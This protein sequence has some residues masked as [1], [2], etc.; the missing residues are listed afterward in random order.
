MREPR[1]TSR[2]V[3]AAALLHVVVAS[4]LPAASESP[5]V[6][7]ASERLAERVSH[8]ETLCGSRPRKMSVGSTCTRA[9]TVRDSI[10]L[11]RIIPFKDEWD[12]NPASGTV[13]FSRDRGSFVFKTVRGDLDRNV[14]VEELLVVRTADLSASLSP[15][16]VAIGAQGVPYR[17][18]VSVVVS[19]AWG[20]I[21]D[22]RWINDEE[23]GYIAQGDTNVTQAF[24]VNSKTGKTRQLTHS[25]GDV[26]GFDVHRDRIIYYA[27]A[28]PDESDVIP[29]EGKTVDELLAPEDYLERQIFPRLTL[30]T[31]SRES[32]QPTKINAPTVRLYEPFHLLWLSPSGTLAISLTPATDAP[33]GWSRYLFPNQEVFGY[34]ARQRRSDP[35]SPDLQF[36]TRYQ[37]I[38]LRKNEVRPILD[39][40]SGYV[41][42]TGRAIIE[43]FW[44]EDEASVVISNTLLPLNEGQGDLSMRRS[45]P[46]IAE[47]DVRSG[48]IT[49][50]S[51][52]PTG[53]GRDEAR[54]D[55]LHWDPRAQR[56][57]IQWIGDGSATHAGDSRGAEPALEHTTYF[58]KQ[59]PQWREVHANEAGGGGNVS[60]ELRQEL[61]VP[62]RLCVA[63]KGTLCLKEIYS[64]NPDI[65]DY[66]FGKVIPYSWRDKDALVWS[67]AL[68]YP[69]GREGDKGFPLIIQ[70]HGFQPGE[71]LVD[72]P[73]G[74]T[75]AF[76]AQPLANAGF[77]VLQLE[78]NRIAETN[79]EQE[80]VRYEK[81]IRAAVEDLVARGLVDRS[82][83]GLI[84]WSRTS[85][86]AL[87]VLAANP[88]MFAAA[89]LAD[90]M[91]PGYV[92]YIFNVN[93]NRDLVDQINSVTGGP[94]KPGH[95]DEWMRRNPLYSLS[96]SKTPLRLEAMGVYSLTRMWETYATLK[97]AGHPVD[98]LYFPRGV[99]VLT[100]PSERLAS[101]QG[102]VDWFGFWLQRREDPV[103]WKVDQ[104]ARWRRLRDVSNRVTRS[105]MTHN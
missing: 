19:T 18:L 40:P 25:Q 99:H 82:R 22:V 16:D 36:R 104:Y 60:V 97:Y 91:Q 72:G 75:T 49:P 63:G 65:N 23:V 38:D 42:N 57:S 51:W 79:N 96:H 39:A 12:A 44:L 92:S 27:V 59:G 85:F 30:F 88:G 54:I 37:L 10:Q 78:E 17:T 34:A 62:P 76:A 61:N 102:N 94:P 80:G 4:E 46:A 77:L 56:L 84:G 6:A 7:S 1:F 28:A 32:S 87:H 21:S 24:I 66:A 35:T 43:A 26:R 100:K 58:Q 33:M 8:D 83:I 11:T 31:E 69:P 50:I 15:R 41:I 5:S 55:S 73:F 74:A 71:F 93:S 52:E 81:G 14:N 53:A 103:A 70:T 64:P 20:G 95:L 3:F 98:Y 68:I 101:Q 47:V 105:S 29:V 48:A 90:G 86:H 89:T 67:A 9:F 45:V 2:A 13:L